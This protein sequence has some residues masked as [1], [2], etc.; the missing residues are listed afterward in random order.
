MRSG[1]DAERGL[2]LPQASPETLA[3]RLKRAP[4]GTFVAERGGKLLGAP[5]QLAVFAR[6]TSDEHE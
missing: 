5:W 3:S 6:P 4:L 1:R 2:S